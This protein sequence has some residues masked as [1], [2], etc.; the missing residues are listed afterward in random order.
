MAA[1]LRAVRSALDKTGLIEIEAHEWRRSVVLSGRAGSWQRF[2]DAG[3]AATG[4]GYRGVVNDIEVDGLEKDKQYLPPSCPPDLEG[5]DFDVVIIGSGIT[6]AAI[7]RELTRWD[8]TVA[9]LEKEEDV[10]KQASSRNNGMIHS[11]LATREGSKCSS[12]NLRGNRLYAEAAAELGF[13]LAWPGLLVLLPAKWQHLLYPLVLLDA[14]RKQVEVSL[15]SRNQVTELEPNVWQNQQ[16]ALLLPA[17]GVVSPYQVTA[18]YA[19]NAV[20]NGACIYLNTAALGFVMDGSSISGVRTNRGT[21]KSRLVIN[22]AGIWADKVAG[23]ANDRFFTIHPRKGAIAILDRKTAALQKM[24]VSMSQLGKKSSS[25]GGSLTPTADGNILIGPNALEVPWREDYSTTPADI[26]FLVTRHLRLNR[27]LQPGHII[28]YFAGLRACT[29]EED[30]I[31]EPSEYVP[32][33]IHAAGIQSPGLTAA[34]AIAVDVAEMAVTILRQMQEV[35]PNP[36]FN[37]RRDA[38]P[39]LS[40][41]SLEERAAI[42][43]ANPSYGRIVCR[44]E[45]VSEGEITASLHSPLPVETLDGV[46]RRVRA[47]MGRCQG[48]FC[49]PAVLNIIARETGRDV[50]RVCKKEAGSEMLL[51]FT[52]DQPPAQEEK[53]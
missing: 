5:L 2:I 26:D 35:R 51:S 19:E 30:F 32:N 17:T 53:R 20:E 46:K 47:G 15:L 3:Y 8:I 50:T 49:T 1:G 36:R 13:K 52:K 22:A 42:I 29:F 48:G 14:A 45:A 33:L 11:G 23:L 4:K 28:N 7:A 41:L 16:G 40:E 25:K 10:A 38:N 18:A 6:G 37:P 43:A 24:I 39:V 31:V 12:Y 44:C 9:L 34:P 21:L 27:L